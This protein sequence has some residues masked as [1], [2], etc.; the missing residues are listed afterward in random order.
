MKLSK[1]LLSISLL[2]ISLSGLASANETRTCYDQ[3]AIN[4][5]TARWKI[6]SIIAFEFGGV[7]CKTAY[8]SEADSCAASYALDGRIGEFM[9]SY[10]EGSKDCG[11]QMIKTCNDWCGLYIS[12]VECSKKCIL[13]NYKIV[14]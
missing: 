13:V 7:F 10:V 1:I 9:A 3:H 11:D 5:F 2:F 4:D 6:A 12:E 14:E 8:N